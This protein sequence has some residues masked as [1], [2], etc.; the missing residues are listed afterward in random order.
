MPLNHQ[1]GIQGTLGC[2]FDFIL[3]KQSACLLLNKIN[4]RF[5]TTKDIQKMP[6]GNPSFL[7]TLFLKNKE[8]PSGKKSE[9]C[10]LK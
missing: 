7:H 3:Y 8:Q 5:H 9:Q 1:V 4:L 6:L 2:G 10:N